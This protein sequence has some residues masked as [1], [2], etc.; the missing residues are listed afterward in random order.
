MEH[1]ICVPTNIFKYPNFRMTQRDLEDFV[2]CEGD[3]G[4]SDEELS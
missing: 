2:K 3:A 4:P 1:L